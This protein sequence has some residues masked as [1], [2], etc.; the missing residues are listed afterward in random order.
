MAL[1]YHVFA[2]KKLK[3]WTFNNALFLHIHIPLTLL[4]IVVKLAAVLE[5]PRLGGQ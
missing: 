5:T 1:C 3:V 2:P 4:T